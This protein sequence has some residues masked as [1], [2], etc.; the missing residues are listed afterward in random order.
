MLFM[1]HSPGDDQS[2]TRTSSAWD[3]VSDFDGK[4]Y[5]TRYTNMIYIKGGN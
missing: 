1:N 4:L 2:T 3:D 5:Y